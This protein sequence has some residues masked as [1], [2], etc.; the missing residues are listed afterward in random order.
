MEYYRA[1]RSNGLDLGSNRD[2]K[3]MKLFKLILKLSKINK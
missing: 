2:I 3:H 1:T